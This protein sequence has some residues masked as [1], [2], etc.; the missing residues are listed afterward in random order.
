MPSSLP[1][2][3]FTRLLRLAASEDSDAGSLAMP[4]DAFEAWK[5]EGPAFGKFVLLEELGRG[6]QSIVRRAWQID[7]QREVALKIVTGLNPE[8]RRRFMEEARLGA[9]LSHAAILP[10]FEAGEEG[11]TLW[12]SMPRIIGPTLDLAGLDVGGAV[13]AVASAARAV[14]AAHEQGVIH[15]DLK[16][17]NILKS[18]AG[19]HVLDLGLAKALDGA[20]RTT[21]SGAALGTPHFMS[22]EQ[23]TGGSLTPRTDVYALGATLYALLAKRPPYETTGMDAFIAAMR[24][25][26]APALRTVAPAIPIALEAIVAKAMD[27][28]P[29]RRYES[30]AALADDLE[31]FSAGE[32][33]A[34]RPASVADRASRW[35]RRNPAFV[36]TVSTLLVALAIVATARALGWPRRDSNSLQVPDTQSDLFA[37]AMA[38]TA[39]KEWRRAEAILSRILSSDPKHV[40]AL[41]ERARCAMALDKYEEAAGDLDL[42]NSISPNVPHRWI[43]RGEC[44]MWLIQFRRAEDDYS[45]VIELD[46]ENVEGWV[47]RASARLKRDDA[48]RALEDADEAVKRNPQH[49]W[50]HG[51]R[52]KVLKSLGRN[53]DAL[54]S[55]DEALLRFPRYGSWLSDRGRIKLTMKDFAGALADL[56]AGAALSDFERDHS[57]DDIKA[58]EQG[59]KAANPE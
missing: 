39:K 38:L 1:D 16:P 53:L 6:G 50:A 48:P 26:G 32:P 9:R 4:P 45:K 19:I 17:R 47:G 25:D 30:A 18:A 55:Y 13:M 56:K 23:V 37:D 54:K 8:S 15:R 31:R 36:A 21:A 58:A 22:P 29:R 24:R 27:H 5:R 42:A 7:L 52:G 43:L 35:T 33:I 20:S 28:D 11:E 34:A 44:S 57:V 12:L 3:V 49:A 14:Q 51:V 40:D 46:P 10:V 41:T 2:H 59:L